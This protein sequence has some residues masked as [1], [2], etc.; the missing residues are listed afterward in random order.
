MV[1]EKAA[2]PV[3]RDF[4]SRWVMYHQTHDTEWTTEGE[5]TYAEISSPPWRSI[6]LRRVVAP[7]STT[8][9]EGQ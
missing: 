9:R 3:E 1:R 5:Y 4:K 2:P 8:P 6:P 7:A